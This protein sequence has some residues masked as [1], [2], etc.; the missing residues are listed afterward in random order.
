MGHHR[1]I[2]AA[3]ACRPPNNVPNHFP[4]FI[5]KSLYYSSRIRKSEFPCRFEFFDFT[6]NF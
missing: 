1:R 6:S 4:D 5:Q 3:G 2:P